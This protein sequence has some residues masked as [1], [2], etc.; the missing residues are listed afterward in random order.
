MRQENKETCKEYSCGR[1]SDLHDQRERAKY[2]FEEFTQ[3]YP[4]V[5]PLP[6][7]EDE[8]FISFILK[9]TI[10]IS[11]LTWLPARGNEN[12][13]HTISAINLS[14]PN[15][16]HTYAIFSIVPEEEDLYSCSGETSTCEEYSCGRTSEAKYSITFAVCCPMKNAFLQIVS[17]SRPKALPNLEELDSCER[18]SGANLL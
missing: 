14:R 9:P 6:Q 16:P 15:E 10:K 7:G 11:T 13:F 17:D 3:L 2:S 1:T 5:Y 18:T 12:P 8:D 4:D